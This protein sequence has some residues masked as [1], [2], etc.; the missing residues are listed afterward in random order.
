[1][2]FCAAVI[3]ACALE[4]CFCAVSSARCASAQ[5]LCAAC[6][7][8]ASWVCPPRTLGKTLFHGGQVRAA[9]GELLALPALQIAQGEIALCHAVGG[10]RQSAAL[11]L[12]LLLLFGQRGGLRVDLAHALLQC[13]DLRGDAAA[14]AVLILQLVLHALQVA[15][16]VAAIRLQ[17]GD[18]AALLLRGGLRLPDRITDL[19]RLQVAV[20]E[21]ERQGFRGN[22]ELVQRV[23]L[24][25]QDEGG[26]MIVLLGLARRGAQALER[27]PATAR[28][29]GP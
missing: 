27:L 3:S 1:M 21:I 29:Q 13:F 18:P 7:S 9:G 5:R 22:I 20:V 11:L 19:I 2:R 24:L 6:R 28:P 14:A 16:R 17:H 4:S 26:G 8:C 12:G 15:L 23:V 10:V 25:L